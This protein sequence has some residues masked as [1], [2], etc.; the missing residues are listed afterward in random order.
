MPEIV[1]VVTNVFSWVVLEFDLGLLR[2][3]FVT[4][5]EPN[6]NAE[7]MWSTDNGE[8]TLLLLLLDCLHERCSSDILHS[9]FARDSDCC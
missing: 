2:L 4:M 9:K 5:P 3:R 8:D 7:L 6:R 1:S